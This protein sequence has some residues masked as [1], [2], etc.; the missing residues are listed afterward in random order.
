MLTFFACP[1]TLL[2]ELSELCP[3]FAWTLSTYVSVCAVGTGWLALI[4]LLLLS[5]ARL[6]ASSASVCVVRIKKA[7][8]NDKAHFPL[9]AP[10]GRIISIPLVHSTHLT[11]SWMN[12]SVTVCPVRAIAS[13]QKKSWKLISRHPSD[14]QSLFLSRLLL[15]RPLLLL[16]CSSSHEMKKRLKSIVKYKCTRGSAKKSKSDIF[17]TLSLHNTAIV[18]WF[19][20]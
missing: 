8:L 13:E 17:S 15:S 10:S 6:E 12:R 11:R 16:C 14:T 4:V 20:C 2:H 19:V 1:S 18:Q 5:Q 7:L 3:V 9:F